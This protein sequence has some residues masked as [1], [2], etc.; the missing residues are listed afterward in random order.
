MIN[1]L[2]HQ[3]LGKI[4]L[5]ISILF[6]ATASGACGLHFEK[7]N[8]TLTV[9]A[10]QRPDTRPSCI[11]LGLVSVTSITNG[12][13]SLEQ[14][15]EGIPQSNSPTSSCVEFYKRINKPPVWE[16]PKNYKCS[17]TRKA[18]CKDNPVSNMDGSKSKI[19]ISYGEICGELIS[20]I[21]NSPKTWR[22]VYINDVKYKTVCE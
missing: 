3:Y 16:T 5:I 14:M 1:F 21:R 11:E 9:I 8:N 4:A 18:L 17:S 2:N 6:V 10:K 15:V 20:E 13:Y 12:Q 7:T 22:V 19:R